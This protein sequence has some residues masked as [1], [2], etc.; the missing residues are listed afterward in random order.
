MLYSSG[1]EMLGE[2]VR[3]GSGKKRKV[4]LLVDVLP[5][6]KTAQAPVGLR[7]DGQHRLGIL[8]DTRGGDVFSED[9]S[10]QVVRIVVDRIADVEEV[11]WR[12]NPLERFADS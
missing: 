12:V 10:T 3:V 2:D 7:Y 4:G 1:K 6:A 9:R 5:G 8:C 11:C